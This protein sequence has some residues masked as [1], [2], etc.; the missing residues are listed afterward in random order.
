ML[1]L[2]LFDNGEMTEQLRQA[3]L[4]YLTP[5]M[6]QKVPF[7]TIKQM[8]DALHNSQFGLVIN[9]AMIMDL[10]NPE[11]V[12][13]VDKIEGDR[14]FLT[15]PDKVAEPSEGD[16]EQVQQNKDHVTSMA[17]DKIKQSLTQPAAAAAPNPQAEKPE[18]PKQS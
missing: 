10:L 8:I 11:Q 9:R 16:A 18:L 15:N 12:Q 6:S 14:I 3:A 4:D 1:L 2:E 5:F 13:A 7:V 17:V